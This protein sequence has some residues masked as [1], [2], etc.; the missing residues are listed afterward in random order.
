MRLDIPCP[1][2]PPI[3]CR[4]FWPGL[5]SVPPSS[6]PQPLF[7]PFHRTNPPCLPAESL[8]IH[9]SIG[10]QLTSHR[11]FPF[12]SSAT[13][14]SKPSKTR[15]TA[16]GSATT[17]FKPDPQNITLVISEGLQGCGGR[18]YLAVIEGKGEEQKEV[19]VVFPVRFAFFPFPFRFRSPF[20]SVDHPPS[21]GRPP[22]SA[23]RRPAALA[24]DSSLPLSPRFQSKKRRRESISVCIVA[25]EGV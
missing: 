2:L 17:R 23:E 18:Y 7:F 12:L 13:S 6:P 4:A 3:A 5:L 10:I 24:I 1:P 25:S 9:P 15:S 11:F 22:A 19:E 20:S 14:T 21:T 8:E 16:R